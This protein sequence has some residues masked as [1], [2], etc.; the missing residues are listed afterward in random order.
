MEGSQVRSCDT[1][2]Q[3]PE[4]GLDLLGVPV[5]SLSPRSLLGQG[6]PSHATHGLKD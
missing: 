3:E 2:P 6:K 1:P 5:L 4:V